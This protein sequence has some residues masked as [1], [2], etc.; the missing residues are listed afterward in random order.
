MGP[1]GARCRF[2]FLDQNSYQASRYSE[3]RLLRHRHDL[4]RDDNVLTFLFLICALQS[5]LYIF[6]HILICENAT[7]KLFLLR[8]HFTP[9]NQVWH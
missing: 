7:C 6:P 2:I 4:H 8:P 5:I 3:T 9:N 1:K